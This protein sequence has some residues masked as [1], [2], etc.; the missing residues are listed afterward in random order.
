MQ[1]RRENQPG[2]PQSAARVTVILS[3]KT[4]SRQ[5][6]R[7]TSTGN[8]CDNPVLKFQQ[9]TIRNEM[10]IRP[11]SLYLLLRKQAPHSFVR[12]AT[13]ASLIAFAFLLQ[14]CG[15]GGSSSST[16]STVASVAVT[17]TSSSVSVNG[18]QTFTAN[19]LDSNGQAVAGQTFTWTSSNTAVATITSAG[20]ATGL[21]AGSSQITA[22]AGGVTSTA[23][24]LT[25]NPAIASVSISPTAATI[26]VGA[27]Q[28][29]T[30]SA[31][32]ASGNTVT[33]ATFTWNNSFGGIATIDST[34]LATAL[35]PGSVMITASAGGV[36]SP[37]ATLT[38][39]P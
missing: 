26:K 2:A 18:Q 15:G 39:T 12:I 34:G 19:A 16:S 9:S 23:A 37:V 4:M 10:S 14:A 17:P 24:T 29:F 28:Q 30:A 25:V 11:R 6:Q 38:V 32:D 3:G 33:Q 31:K 20:V 1:A 13:V 27:T 22:S 5:Q 7:F 36:T 21:K 8:Y 35:A